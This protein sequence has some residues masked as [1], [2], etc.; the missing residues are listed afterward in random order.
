[1]RAT[2]AE[3]PDTHVASKRLNTPMGPF[4]VIA[5]ESGIIESA[6]NHCPGE[7]LQDHPGHRPPFHARACAHLRAAGVQV[8]E[9]LARRRRSFDLPLVP[10]GTPFQKA[11]WDALLEISC[12]STL[13]YGELARSLDRPA[14]ARAVG[15]ACHHNPL[16]L[17]IPCHR[18]L[19]ASGSLTGYGG[20]ISVKRRLLEHERGLPLF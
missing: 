4:C 19:G 2:R 18:V 13:T 6:F 17:F 3:P 11:V 20:G 1:M 12:G 16:S 9:Y 5:S 8:E 10:R 15:Q 7:N 14:A